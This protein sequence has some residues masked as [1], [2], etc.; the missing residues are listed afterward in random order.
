MKKAFRVLQIVTVL[1]F[2][3]AAVCLLTGAISFAD[4]GIL[5]PQG[6]F[7]AGVAAAAVVEGAPPT[8]TNAKT[9]ADGSFLQNTIS[10]NITKMKPSATPLDTIIRSS[11]KS[12]N[13]PSWKYD[14]YAVDMRGV[15]DTV[16]E[17]YSS[18]GTA[19]AYPLKV[20][21]MHQYSVDDNIVLQGI[22]GSDNQD[23]VCNITAKNI[24]TGYLTVT[25]LNGFGTDTNELTSVP[26][27]TKI[28]RMGNAKSELDAQTDPYTI[29]PD[30]SWNYSQI[31][32]CQVEESVYLELHK[33]EVSYGMADYKY[34]ALYDYRRGIEFDSLWGVRKLIV[35]STDGE[36]KY[37]T[38]GLTRFIDQLLTFDTNETSRA[39]WSEFWNAWM[40]AIFSD[41]S[42]SESRTVF[43]GKDLMERLNNIDSV[44][45]QIDAKSTNMVHGITFNRIESNFGILDLKLHN[46]FA[47][48]GWGDR[49][50]VLDMPN[51]E[52]FTYKGLETTKLDLKGSGQ[53]NANAF[54]I[55]EAFGL[56]LRY[57][58]THAIIK[59]V[60]GT[61]LV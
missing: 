47:P 27:N 2:V 50:I 37:F 1:S 60:A 33:K 34:A 40:K 55:D 54:K 42:G 57:P 52:K 44:Q 43:I 38:G 14:F 17:A 5:A 3:F 28:C 21:S 15:E 30:K 48:M 25:P 39:K 16:S 58:K 41:N 12:I 19:G 11:P 24:G 56:A 49:A 8:T 46:L 53:R 59:G 45:R 4:I 29:F 20:T 9:Q 23:I 7:T 10:Q 36:E 32:M 22:T 18:G 6:I 51:I 35:D 31:H 61:P 26:L 13:A